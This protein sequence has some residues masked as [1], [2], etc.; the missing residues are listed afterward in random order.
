MQDKSYKT[1]GFVV[2]VNTFVYRGDHS[3]DVC[4]HVEV[5]DK[6]ASI[7]QSLCERLLD[8]RVNDS[9]TIKQVEALEQ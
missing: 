1:V 6:E 5:T 9:I 2:S 7:I 8:G 4:R 3:A